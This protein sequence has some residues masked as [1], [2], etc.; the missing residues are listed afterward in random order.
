MSWF[1]N[2]IANVYDI[3]SALFSWFVRGVALELRGELEANDAMIKAARE[4]HVE[5]VKQ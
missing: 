5:I 4:G 1:K 3:V 2:A